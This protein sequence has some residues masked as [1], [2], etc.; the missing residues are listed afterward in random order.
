[1][2]S[3]AVILQELQ[4]LRQLGE[5]IV[6]RTDELL[7]QVNAGADAPKPGPFTKWDQVA[8]F[9]GVSVATLKRRRKARPDLDRTRSSSTPPRTCTRVVAKG[10][11]AGSED[12]DR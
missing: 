1:M 7:T 9:V 2:S 12:A 8:E 5:V 4:S 11:G 6:R 3:Q 10:P